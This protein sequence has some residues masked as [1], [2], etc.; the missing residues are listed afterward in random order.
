MKFGRRTIGIIVAATI[1]LALFAGLVSATPDNP[2]QQILQVLF[3]IEEKID[4]SSATQILAFYEGEYQVNEGIYV[5]IPGT[6]IEADK[7]VRFTVSLHLVSVEL[8]DRVRIW[9]PP[10][11]DPQIS[12]MEIRSFDASGGLEQRD[13][14]TF[15]ATLMEVQVAAIDPQSVSGIGI[16]WKIMVEGSPGTIVTVQT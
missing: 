13:T 16:K 3:R 6:E 11:G 4:D 15:A 14:V 12:Y 8:T 10:H 7:P 1:G 2:L 9:V 5:P